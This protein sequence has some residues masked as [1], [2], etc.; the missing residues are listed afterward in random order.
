MS[1]LWELAYYGEEMG[2]L[3]MK[4]KVTWDQGLWGV[5]SRLSKPEGCWELLWLRAEMEQL[6]T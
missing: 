1:E 5:A 3:V 4:S 6:A 2:S